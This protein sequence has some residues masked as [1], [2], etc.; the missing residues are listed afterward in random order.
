MLNHRLSYFGRDYSGKSACE[1][2]DERVFS[3]AKSLNHG[4]S[5]QVESLERWCKIKWNIPNHLAANKAIS[6]VVDEMT[7]DGITPLPL[8]FLMGIFLICGC[9]A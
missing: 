6:A 5:Q 7:L 4:G 1:V 2:V 8:V 9:Y 3:M